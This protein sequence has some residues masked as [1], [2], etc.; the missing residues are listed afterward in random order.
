[1]PPETRPY[2]ST[3]SAKRKSHQPLEAITAIREYL[4]TSPDD[5][6]GIMLLA[7]IQAEDLKDLPSAEKTLDHFCEWGHAS[8]EQVVAALTQLADWHL[9]FHRNASPAK[10]MLQRI[11]DKYPGTAVARAAQERIAHLEDAGKKSIL[12]P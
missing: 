5:F 11:V 12:A 4:S 10:A 2:Y 9:K 8:R 7:T 6:E 3:V 1:M